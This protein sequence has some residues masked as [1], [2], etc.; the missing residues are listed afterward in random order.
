MLLTVSGIRKSFGT[1]V[2]LDGLSFRVQA[3]EKV[4]LVGRNGAG[5]TTLLKIITGQE[6]PDAGSVQ[7]ARNAKIGYLRQEAPV[8]KGSTVL[9]E[10][11]GALLDQLQLKARLEALEAKLHLNDPEDLEEY[12]LLHE[13]FLDAE[14]YSAEHDV[15][16]VLLRMGFAEDEF[17]K[18][19]EMLSGGEKT[20]LALA[21]LLL[22]EPDILILDEP[23]NHLDLQATE[24]LEGWLRQYHGAVLLVSHDRAFLQNAADRVIELRDGGAKSYPGPFE[25]Y[26]TLRAEE[27]ARQ[28]EVAKR[29]EQ[30]IAKLDEFVRRFMNSQRTAQARGRQKLMNRLIESKVSAPKIEKGIK[31]GFKEASRSGDLAVVAENLAIGYD[32]EPLAKDI[33]W[34][35]SYGERWGVVGENGAGKSTLVK[36]ALGLL[37]PLG[38]KVRLGAGVV[39][40]YFSQ[41]ASDLDLDSTPLEMFVWE[42]DLTPPEARDLLGRFL[43]T[44]DDVFRPIRTLSGGEKNKLSLARLTRL[45]PNLLILDE[46]TN[47]LDMASR[48]ALADVLKEFKGTLVLVSHDR[49]LLN[50]VA[51]RTLDLR[52]TGAIQFPGGYDEYRR[53]QA[54][55][56]AA[57]K[58]ATKTSTAEATAPAMSQRE[59]SKEL[60]KAQKALVKAEDDVEAQETALKAIEA[61]LADIPEGADVVALTH[62]Y[63]AAEGDLSKAMEAW[64]EAGKRLESLKALR[65][66]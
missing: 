35:V 30:E 52:R 38:G 9:A 54:K 1:D 59:L 3:K 41:D 23:T 66:G 4:A 65:G 39:A 26:L 32:G 64:E 50:Q 12:A 37:D 2:I 19:T 8:A 7:L 58:V 10:A 51:D 22:E 28:V 46:P 61:Q 48:E 57:P 31:A 24:W 36:V 15:R 18:S 14:G 40:G 60:E 55:A 56:A 63:Q 13:R 25:K 11:E 6:T 20:R 34:T 27:E 62:R 5:K 33:D 47:H 43:I 42:L 29:Q 49:W 53:R 17:S 21:R 16:T 44:G 45:N